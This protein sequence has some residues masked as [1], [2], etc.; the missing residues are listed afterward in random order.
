MR[1]LVVDDSRVTRRLLI[2]ILT[3]ECGIDECAEAVDGQE[4]VEAVDEDTF[5]IILMDWN[6]PRLSGIDAIE[7]IREKGIET[8]IIMVTTESEKENIVR[9]FKAGANNYIIKPFS[10]ESVSAK[11][12]NVVKSAA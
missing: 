8:P 4:S 7:Q 3:E 1:A 5:D 12:L 11:V 9:A 10:S 2:N 6:M